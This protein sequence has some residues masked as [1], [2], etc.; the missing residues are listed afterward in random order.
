MR[1]L[2]NGHPRRVPDRFSLGS[3][4]PEGRGVAIALNGAVVRQGDWE[5]TWLAEDDAVEVLTASQGG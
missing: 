3:L 5:V 2:V 4:V 1:I